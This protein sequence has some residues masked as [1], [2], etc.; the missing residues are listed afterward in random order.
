MHHQLAENVIRA[1]GNV[2]KMMHL[3]ISHVV[4]RILEKTDETINICLEG[5]KQ[6]VYFKIDT[7]CIELLSTYLDHLANFSS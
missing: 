5:Q 7:N 1:V 6:I 2:Q 4:L 3:G